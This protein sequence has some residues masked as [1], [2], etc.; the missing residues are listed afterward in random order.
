MTGVPEPSEQEEQ[1]I[2]PQG[3][4][5]RD[6][7]LLFQAARVSPILR[8]AAE[9]T[10]AYLELLQTSALDRAARVVQLEEALIVHHGARQN[11][12]QATDSDAIRDAFKVMDELAAREALERTGE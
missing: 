12:W 3:Q 4:A 10:R 5:W 1:E 7:E 9:R 11:G 6:L 8:E 2:S